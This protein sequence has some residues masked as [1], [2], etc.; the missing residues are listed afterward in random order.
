MGG[1]LEAHKALLTQPYQQ[2]RGGISVLLEP[3][4][5]LLFRDTVYVAAFHW[6]QLTFKGYA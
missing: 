4:H 5:S 2:E 6:T 3:I 1:V